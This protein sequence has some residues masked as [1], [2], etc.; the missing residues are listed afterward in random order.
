[1]ED[2]NVNLNKAS[3]ENRIKCSNRQLSELLRDGTELITNV[4]TAND[5]RELKHRAVVAQ[6]RYDLL[7]ELRAE[8][9]LADEKLAN[10]AALWSELDGYK[11]PISL[12]NGLETLKLKIKDLLNQKDGAIGELHNT[13]TS[14]SDRYESSQ[15]CKDEDIQCLI[16]RIDMH[17]EVMKESYQNHLALLH[18]SIDDER[19]SFKQLHT[20]KW[21]DMYN[22]REET[23]QQNLID[24][25]ERNEMYDTVAFNVQLEHEEMCRNT[26]IRL[27]RDNEKLQIQLRHINAETML[28][29]EKLNYNHHVLQKRTEENVSVRHQQKQ[30]LARMHSAITEIRTVIDRTKQ[31]QSDDIR[32]ISQDVAKLY[33]NVKS[34]K[35]KSETLAT[36]NNQKVSTQNNNLYFMKCLSRI[37]FLV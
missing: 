31:D 18:Q 21:N 4:S 13:L 17:V 28:N 27:D 34:L 19:V 7:N 15:M 25:K 16:E 37:I 23:E 20:N 26:R 29:T 2:G 22:L 33:E 3:I 32:K 11:D 24:I 12:N 36:S 5:R 9:Q 6:E 30:R 14:A 35:Q 10:I 8:S 1:M